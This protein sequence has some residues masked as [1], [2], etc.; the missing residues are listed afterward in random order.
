MLMDD[1][2]VHMKAGDVPVQQ[3]TNHASVNNDTRPCRIV[4]ILIDA[5]EPPAWKL[6]WTG[7]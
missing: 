7:S 1:T 6:G 5:K 3:R 2:E 4:F